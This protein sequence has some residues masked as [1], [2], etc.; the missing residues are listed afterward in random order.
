M[1]LEPELTEE[2]I[3]QSAHIATRRE[4]GWLRSIVKVVLVLNAFDAVFTLYWVE[5]GLAIEANPLL[6]R[7][8]I[9]HPV[10]F[11]V[12]KLLLVSLGSLLLWRL[13]TRR[14]SVVAI[15]LAFLAYYYLLVVHL[16][17]LNLHLAEHL[18]R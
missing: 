4:F 13:R 10:A 3:T 14:A 18:P 1:D 16:S 12:S 11:V 7:I 6:A 2:E 9:S 5:A 15:F 17:G 8:V